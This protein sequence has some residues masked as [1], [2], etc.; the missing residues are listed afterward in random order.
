LKGRWLKLNS[1]LNGLSGTAV[2]LLEEL[3]ELAGDV[4]SVAIEDWSV[5]STDLA[6]VVQDDDL[7]IEGVGALG[8]VILLEVRICLRVV[9]RWEYLGVTSN[10][11]ATH[12]LNGNVLIPDQ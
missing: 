3:G 12:F 4:G 8:R 1:L 2:D 6:R 5:T 10:I 7:G 11:T 9:H